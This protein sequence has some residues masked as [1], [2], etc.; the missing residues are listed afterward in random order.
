MVLGVKIFGAFTA[1]SSH[2]QGRDLLIATAN[3]ADQPEMHVGC[4][5]H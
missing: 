1:S 2:V 3:L 5:I 4:D